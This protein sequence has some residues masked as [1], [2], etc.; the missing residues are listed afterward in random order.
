MTGV[1]SVREVKEMKI[2]FDVFKRLSVG[3]AILIDKYSHREDLFQVWRP[4]SFLLNNSNPIW[5]NFFK[6]FIS[7]Y[8]KV[9]LGW[10]TIKSKPS[11]QVLKK[12]EEQDRLRREWEKHRSYVDPEWCEEHKRL[13]SFYEDR[14]EQNQNELVY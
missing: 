10:K 11:H 2:E 7:L 6:I 12:A 4:G 9:A 3:Q 1:G 5:L 8:K 14:K 13:E